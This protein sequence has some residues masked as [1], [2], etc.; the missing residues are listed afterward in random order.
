MATSGQSSYQLR[1]AVYGGTT[2]GH[3]TCLAISRKNVAPQDVQ[4]LVEWT[5]PVGAPG[6]KYSYSDTGYVLLGAVVERVTG[7]TLPQAMRSELALDKRGLP[8]TYWE[9][10]EPAR[11]PVRARQVCDG[12][13]TYDWNPTM[14]LYGGGNIVA[15]MA[16]VARFFDELLPGKVFK[17]PETL[18]LMESSNGLPANTPYR[19]GLLTYTFE[20]TP[21][22]GHSG[23]WGT[24]V[25]QE[26]TSGQIVA[27]AVTN[28]DDIP[29]LKSIIKD[30]VHRAAEGDATSSC[31]R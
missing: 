18:A 26:P 13:D 19:Y 31:Y 28:H 29:K 5:D 22:I 27:V 4:R 21:A 6:E 25:V 11:G 30:Y 1:R 12:I 14:D 16:D 20:G 23:F 8:D 17:H 2:R 9:R 7:Q 3:R 24:F 10:F 15:S